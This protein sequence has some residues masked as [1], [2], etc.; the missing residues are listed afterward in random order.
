MET[1]TDEAVYLS[2]MKQLLIDHLRSKLGIEGWGDPR[3]EEELMR[4][5]RERDS[6]TAGRIGTVLDQCNKLLYAPHNLDMEVRS[7]LSARVAEV[8]YE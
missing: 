1:I 6:G 5:L 7:A 4:L 2:A 3:A 8:L